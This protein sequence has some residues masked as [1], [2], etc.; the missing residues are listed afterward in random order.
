MIGIRVSVELVEVVEPP[1]EASG[2]SDGARDGAVDGATLGSAEA[3]LGSALGDS[4]GGGGVAAVAVNV[5]VPRA[6][7][8]SRADFEVQRIV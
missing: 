6:T 5:V 2:A 1:L 7:S 3:V 8:P 4:E